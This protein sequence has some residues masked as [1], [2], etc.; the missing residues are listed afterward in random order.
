MHKLKGGVA[1]MISAILRLLFVDGYANF[2]KG[3]TFMYQDQPHMFR[4][5]L[6]GFIADEKGLK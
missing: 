6:Q 2:D 1:A 4:A 5:S 3:S